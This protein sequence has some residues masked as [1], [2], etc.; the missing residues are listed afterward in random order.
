IEGVA[1]HLAIVTHH[2]GDAVRY[3]GA[4]T[5]PARATR[6]GAP[7]YSPRIAIDYAPHEM[8]ATACNDSSP[9]TVWSNRS[10]GSLPRRLNQ[11]GGCETSQHGRG[12]QRG[13]NYMRQRSGWHTSAG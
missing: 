10:K 11:A 6:L 4:T 9:N 12:E 7:R 1:G 13:G 3:W 8:F 2:R 5:M